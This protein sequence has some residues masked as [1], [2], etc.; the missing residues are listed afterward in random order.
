MY[1]RVDD[2]EYDFNYLKK[3]RTHTIPFDVVFPENAIFGVTS[4]K[5]K[6]WLMVII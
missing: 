2:K 4:G 3:F 6:Q 1:L 5:S